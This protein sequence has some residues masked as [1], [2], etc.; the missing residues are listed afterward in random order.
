MRSESA[1]TS[2]YTAQND[3]YTVHLVINDSDKPT[4][5]IDL[6]IP[7]EEVANNI[8]EH[9]NTKAQT[10]YNQIIKLLM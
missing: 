10:I 1:L 4:L 2:D 7:D 5:S 3:S 9:W 8:C 6:D